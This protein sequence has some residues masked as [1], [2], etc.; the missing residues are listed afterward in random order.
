MSAP[1]NPLTCK[2][3]GY[4]NEGERVY[5]HNCGTKLDRTLLPASAEPEETLKKKQKRIRR[6]VMPDRG[7]FVGAGKMFVITM[8]SSMATALVILM[9][10]PPDDVPPMKDRKDLLD[11]FPRRPP[12]ARAI[13]ARGLTSMTANA[14]SAARFIQQHQ[15]ILVDRINRWIGD[16]DKRVI[17]RFLRQ[18]Q[19]LTTAEHMVVPD[20]RRTEKLVELTVVATWH[21]VDGIHR[22]S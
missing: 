20:A 11:I 10:L 18:L 6:I 17:L 13:A 15:S 1:A 5:C 3:C 7:F 4:A 21:V 16:S 2:Q 14:Q 9:L 19:A 12:R 22:L 8:L